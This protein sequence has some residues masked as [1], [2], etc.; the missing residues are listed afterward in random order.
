MNNKLD[1]M[2][3]IEKYE[4]AL[5]DLSTFKES[6][7]LKSSTIKL[8][9]EINNE[10]E[11]I[12]M[13]K[14]I[15]KF[16]DRLKKKREEKD[17]NKIFLSEVIEKEKPKFTNNNLILSPVGSGKTTFAKS[18]IKEN[19]H[20]LFL[21][22]TTSLKES[23][24]P[25]NEEKRRFQKNR[26]YTTKNKKIYGKENYKILIMTYAEFGERIK[27]VDDFAKQFSLIICDEIHSLPLFQ[28]Y[29]NSPTLLVAMRYLFSTHENQPKFYF[30]ATDEHIKKLQKSSEEI[31]RDVTI[32]NYIN[33][34][35]IMK[36]VPLSSY[37]ITSIE[38]VRHHLRARKESF[39]Y[40]GYK[41]FAYCKTIR[42]QERLKEIC[43]DEG[44]KAQMYW[45]TNN[46]EKQ[47]TEQQINEAAKII[48]TGIFPDEYDI[49]IINS[50]MQEGWNLYDE[51]VKLA[52]MNTTNETE[53]V[54][55]LGR[56]RRDLDVLVYKVDKDE[57][58]EQ[59]L[60]IPKK[61][62]DTPLTSI[63]KDE[64][65]EELGLY[66]NN[67]RLYKWQTIKA[68]CKNQGFLI[69]DESPTINGKRQ[70]VSIIH[71]R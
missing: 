50:A 38:Q 1:L 21:V 60:S 13:V 6:S 32:F 51:R 17:H 54:Q 9:G 8:I 58:I 22:S 61:Y 25:N 48:D 43:E 55:S 30:T 15:E 36:Y 49:I 31:M 53:Y 70:R 40:F 66:N 37:K 44:F 18:L 62:L 64:L 69:T 52:I 56:L 2:N 59:F 47:M 10:K 3:E 57:M 20:V 46:E 34:P 39:D 71:S 11:K 24:V 5:I 16:I 45:S 26:M 19:D 33:Y 41:G 67:G 29:D 14:V 27:Y 4:D 68:L 42:S 63:D 28:D 7:T 35:N 23:L 12:S 65:C